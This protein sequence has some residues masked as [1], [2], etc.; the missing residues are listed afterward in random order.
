MDSVAI[1]EVGPRDG[2]QNVSS[3][4]SP[5]QKTALIRKLISKG[6]NSIEA[7][8]FV[9]PDRV[10]SMAGTDEIA[11]S[12]KDN[13]QKLW[14]LVPNLIGLKRALECKVTQIAFFTAASST[15]NQ[16]NTGMS[17]TQSLDTIKECVEYIRDMNY[18]V[19]NHWDQQVKSQHE[20]KLRLYISTVIGC[21]YEGRVNPKMT[22]DIME[23]SEH[24]G[25]AQISLGDTTGVGV[26]RDWKRLFAA[27]D[28]KHFAHNKLALHCHDTYGTAL[29]CVAEGLAQGISAFDSSIG[30]LGGCP[31][32]P[33]ATGN[34]ATEDL[35]YFLNK[36]GV[37]CGLEAEKL[38]DIFSEE[39]T[40]PLQNRSR[41]Y[42]ALKK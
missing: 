39:T 12:L 10:P 32:A 34:L 26:P 29:A 4:L 42:Q 35:V 23:E 22:A 27:L 20:I 25:F 18:H 6:L 9:R 21:P 13:S 36:E 31:F 28:E 24:L 3:V 1:I 8:S 19:I 14:Y 16:K 30:G 5:E 15:F 11:L 40:G 7:G 38:L 2:L 17:T 41:V 37:N 33:G